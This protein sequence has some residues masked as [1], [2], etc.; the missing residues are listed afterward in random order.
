VVQNRANVTPERQQL[1]EKTLGRAPEHMVEIDEGYDFEVVIV[2]DEWVFRFPRRANVVEALEAETVFLPRLA[3]ALP[4]AVP[5][6]EHVSHEP[7]FVTYALI[8]GTPLV[9]EDPDGV[10]ACLDALHAFDHA[11]LPVERR[12]WRDRFR[13]QCARF[14]QD[15]LSLLEPADQARALELFA[16]VE[17]LTGFEPAF[18]HNDL[19][20]VHLIVH[21]GRLA[22]VID[23]GDVVVGD[24]ARDYA[25]LLNVAFPDWDVPD[26]LRRRARFYH[27]L[28]PW[29]E[30]H[31]G[32]FTKQ[33]A[34]VEPAL[35]EISSRL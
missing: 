33:P 13:E 28:I 9:D 31:Y 6:F 3:A 7:S 23:W 15:V 26:E 16:E 8:R 32:V 19:S 1:I 25:W 12:D 5:L 18:I 34:R 17:T 21:E 35:L 27:R 4:V 29:F 24:P 14:E 30:A 22:G 10:R 2:D 11:G 20:G